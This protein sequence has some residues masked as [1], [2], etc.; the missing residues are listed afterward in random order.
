MDSSYLSN[1]IIFLIETISGLYIMTFMLRYL[2]SITQ[3]DFYNP[4]SQFLVKITNPL[5]IPMRRFIPSLGKIDT[6]AIAIMLTLQMLTLFVITLLKGGYV[7]FW[8]VFVHSLA[9][10]IELFL[11][12]FLFSI[13]IQVVISWVNPG[14]N[15]PVTALLYGLT[16]PVMAPIRRIIQPIGGMD[17]SP[18]AAIIGIYILNMLLI[19]P[20]R[21][22][23]GI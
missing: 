20:I 7:S 15:N 14:V 21:H 17:L 11:N 4:V 3:A 16:E 9:N 22:L 8:P 6:A 19:P 10:L 23:A 1:P 5:L 13:L 18:M 12:I 2:L